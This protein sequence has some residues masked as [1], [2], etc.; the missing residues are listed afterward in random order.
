MGLLY[1]DRHDILP[2]I[3]NLSH[4]FICVLVF[5][6]H[7]H[8]PVHTIFSCYRWSN[9]SLSSILSLNRSLHFS[10]RMFH[11]TIALYMLD[12]WCKM[13]HLYSILFMSLGPVSFFVDGLLFPKDKIISFYQF[14]VLYNNYG[15]MN[16]VC[17]LCC[18]NRFL[19][20]IYL[21]VLHFNHCL[22]GY[23]C[24][25]VCVY[26]AVYVWTLYVCVYSRTIA[27]PA[28]VYCWI[29]PDFK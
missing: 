27:V 20:V 21:F 18:F 13:H 4:Y 7:S 15:D 14:H 26:I 6:Y 1:N 17:Q 2:P 25:C 5:I 12:L 22:C 3:W 11:W 29:W 24:V 19:Y 8:I 10:T 28:N 9:C 23:E 16:T